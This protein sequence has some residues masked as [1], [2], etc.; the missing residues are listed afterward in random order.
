MHPK[1][2]PPLLLSLREPGIDFIPDF[3]IFQLV[4]S[5]LH[6][7]IDLEMNKRH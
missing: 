7:L 2:I 5:Y 4:P 1:L 3:D 6:S